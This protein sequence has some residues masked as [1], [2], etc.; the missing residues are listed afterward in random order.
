[1]PVTFQQMV[2][3][4]TVKSPPDR[5]DK[6]YQITRKN[7]KYQK[8][9]FGVSL[10]PRLSVPVGSWCP[11]SVGQNKRTDSSKVFTNYLHS[12]IEIPLERWSFHGF[13]HCFRAAAAF[14]WF[15]AD[16]PRQPVSDGGG[17]GGGLPAE[18]ELGLQQL[19]LLPRLQHRVCHLARIHPACY[20]FLPLRHRPSPP[21]HISSHITS[22]WATFFLSHF[23]S[24]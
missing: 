10:F 7:L 5:L 4:T 6:G 1:M 18:P 20:K 3:F 22:R 14:L 17:N 13:L 8:P 23:S 11:I 15:P 24:L 19:L 9:G 12:P 21:H 16:V 2:Q